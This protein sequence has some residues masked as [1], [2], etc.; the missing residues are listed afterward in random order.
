MVNKTNTIGDLKQ[1]F[2]DKSHS[3]YIGK[4]DYPH[5]NKDAPLGTSL[6]PLANERHYACEN[7]Q[8][9]NDKH[10]GEVKKINMKI[11]YEEKHKVIEEP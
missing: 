5:F 7:I 4:Y 8:Y 2:K 9:F 10:E 6:F 1:Y 11:T 3:L